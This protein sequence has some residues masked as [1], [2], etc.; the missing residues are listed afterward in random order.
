MLKLAYIQIY[1]LSARS[2]RDLKKKHQMTMFILKSILVA[3]NHL[4]IFKLDFFPNQYRDRKFTFGI[5]ALH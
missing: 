2:F 3:V 5:N 1:R 4:S